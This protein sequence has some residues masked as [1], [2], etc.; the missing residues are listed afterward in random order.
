MIRNFLL[1]VLAFF[2][3]SCEKL[4]VG[5]KD[6]SKYFYI[7][8]SDYRVIITIPTPSSDP[9]MA[10]AVILDSIVEKGDTIRLHNKTP[11]GLYCPFGCYDS[12]LVVTLEFSSDPKR[13]LSFSGSIPND[14]AEADI[15]SV[16]SYDVVQLG[17]GMSELFYTINN[18]HYDKAIPCE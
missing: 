9:F 13:C 8:N 7:N 2:A 11:E 3:I 5:V 17:D 10:D 1:I 15:R 4:D 16:A 6:G 18:T 14:A 12:S